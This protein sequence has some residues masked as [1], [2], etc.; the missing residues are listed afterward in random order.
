MIQRIQ[1]LYLLVAGIFP[2]ISLFVPLVVFSEGARWA[3]MSAFGC[4][5]ALVQELAGFHPYGLLV[6]TLLASLSALYA[7]FGYKNRKSQ[8]K[9]VYLTIV[10]NVMTIVFNVIWYVALGAYTYSVSERIGLGYTFTISALLPIIALIA[11]FLALKGIRKD[12]ALVRAADRI[13]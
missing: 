2:V 7:I 3:S 11:L 10:F 6:F 13:R 1:T 4:E 12:E 8:I 5:S 9:K